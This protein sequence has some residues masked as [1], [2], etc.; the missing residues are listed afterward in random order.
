MRI[1]VIRYPGSNCFNDT[2]KKLK[3]PVLG[4]NVSMYNS[5]DNNDIPP[6]VVIVMVGIK[7]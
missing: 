6:S 2:C 5:T 4:G 7:E 1:G 3:I